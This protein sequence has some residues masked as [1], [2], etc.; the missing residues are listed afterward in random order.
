ML[1]WHTTWSCCVPFGLSSI[2]NQ[3]EL[4]QPSNRS[5]I[6]VN[7]FFL[8]FFSIFLLTPNQ[9]ERR[10]LKPFQEIR[11][12][13][14]Q[15]FN[16]WNHLKDSLTKKCESSNSSCVVIEL[17]TKSNSDR[18]EKDWERPVCTAEPSSENWEFISF[19]VQ[20]FSTGIPDTVVD[21]L[22]EYDDHLSR[23]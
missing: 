11:Y 15:T 18:W 5:S 8:F 9:N 3:L 16:H 12:S 17:N 23:R 19:R 2:H 7:Q 6:D 22:E 14:W 4:W 13:G 1:A 21:V 10:I 20:H